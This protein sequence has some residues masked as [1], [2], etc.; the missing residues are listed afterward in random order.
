[1]VL[2]S[3]NDDIVRF[4]NKDGVELFQIGKGKTGSFTYDTA[5]TSPNWSMMVV[6]FFKVM[7]ILHESLV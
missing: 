1:M 3:Y 4:I 2:S 5:T 6:I 7:S